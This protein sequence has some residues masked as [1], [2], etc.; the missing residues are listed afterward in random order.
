M[1]LPLRKRTVHFYAIRLRAYTARAD[2]NSPSC[3][4]L[5]DLLHCFAKMAV[6]SKLPLSVRRAPRLHTV[7]A[8]WR[9]DATANCYELLMSK[10]NAAV[11]DVAL[12]ELDTAR[13]RKAG[14]T[15][16]EGIEMSSHLLLRPNADGKSAALLLTLGAAVSARDVAILLKRLSRDAAKNPRNR[17]LFHFDDPSG[18]KDANG[19]PMQYR[20]NYAFHAEAHLGQTLAAALQSGE[21][22]GME[23]IAHEQSAFDTGG[24]LQVTERSLGVQAKLP[25]AVTGASILNAVRAFKQRPDGAGYDRLRIHYKTVAGQ[26]ASATLAINDLDAS[27]TRKEHIEFDSDVEAQQDSLSPI[28]LAG[29]KPLLKLVP[30]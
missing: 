28:I 12:R 30:T 11:S 9:H 13:L 3:A 25:K 14:K 21:F 22:D 24:N 1:P 18:A 2:I 19:K 17:A 5:P 20:V 26:R 29:M 6:G 15:K 8:D 10:A 16:D 4:P 23:L 27:F 7:L